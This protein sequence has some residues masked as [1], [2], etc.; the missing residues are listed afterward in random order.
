MNFKR[1]CS[2][3]FTVEIDELKEDIKK[4]EIIFKKKP[5]P[6]DEALLH[7]IYDKPEDFSKGFDTTFNR[8][9]TVLDCK[10][11]PEQ[12]YKLTAG[13]VYMDVMVILNDGTSLPNDMF[14][15]D[16]VAQ[17]LFDEVQ[18]NEV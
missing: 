13:I 2:A 16:D 8:D 9:I 1:N 6:K 17:T 11:G 15:I 7:L 14:V 10:L 12:T 5:D 4:V 3:S 18:K